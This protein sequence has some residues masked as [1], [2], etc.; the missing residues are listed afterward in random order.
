MYK[1]CEERG[2][3]KL[4]VWRRKYYVWFWYIIQPCGYD[5][6]NYQCII[7]LTRIF[8]YGTASLFRKHYGT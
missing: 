6:F 7:L 3:G 4:K 5:K 2:H 1:R 8:T